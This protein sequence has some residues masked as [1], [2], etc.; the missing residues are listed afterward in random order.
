MWKCVLHCH[1]PEIVWIKKVIGS[2]II[3]F[4]GLLLFNITLYLV[5][6]NLLKVG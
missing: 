6:K 2:K 3:S 1:N 5:Y 4:Y